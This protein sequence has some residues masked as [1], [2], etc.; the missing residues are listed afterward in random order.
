M[1]KNIHKIPAAIT[2]K[3]EQIES[4]HII[5]ATSISL[6]TEDLRTI[7]YNRFTLIENGENLS[8]EPMLPQSNYGRYSKRNVEGYRIV[9][10]DLPKVLQTY[11]LGERPI[12]GDWANGSFS[13]F[14]TR[15]VY[16]K[17]SHPPT[18][19]EITA[20][21]ID[22]QQINGI[23]RLVIKFQV[24]LVL[25]KTSDDFEEKL[26]TNLNLLSENVGQYDV[27]AADAEDAELLR[28]VALNWEVFPP[29]DREGDI[30]RIAARMRN[31][32]PAT[33]QRIQERYDYLLQFNPI[34]CIQGLNGMRR[35]FG[36]RFRDDLV[37]FENMEAG[38]AIYILFGNW[39]ELSQMSRTEILNQPQDQ[40]VRIEHRRHWRER[41]ANVLRDRL[42]GEQAA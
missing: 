16:Q 23:D 13:L 25:D 18:E 22:R 5:V 2:A 8:F 14:V 1:G 20:T 15:E 7:P 31:P 12:W 6:S 11:Y 36:M 41:L 21:V 26:L 29:G 3:I 9:K 32:N 4:T 27:F 40:Y 19:T 24:D 17:V 42:N 38:N 37:V 34:D 33:L 28:V 30:Q 39:A 10:K 35:Y